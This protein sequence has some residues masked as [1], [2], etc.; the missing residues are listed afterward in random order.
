MV[1]FTNL[2]PMY[3]ILWEF[4]SRFVPEKKLAYISA[5]V[6]AK[7]AVKTQNITSLDSADIWNKR[8]M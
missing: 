1:V 8:F 7:F 2:N 5:L 3:N 4:T 6:T